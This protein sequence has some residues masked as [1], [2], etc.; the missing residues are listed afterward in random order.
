MPEAGE[1]DVGLTVSCLRHLFTDHLGTGN[2]LPSGPCSTG[3]YCPPG[4]TLA[5]PPSFRCPRGFYCP[6]GSPQPRACENGTFQPQEAQGTCKPCP[7]GFYCEASGSGAPVLAQTLEDFSI[8]T[9]Y[10]KLEDQSLHMAAQLSKHRSDALT[11]YKTAS[12]QL[13]GLQ[14][15]L[16]GL[17][18][19]GLQA[20]GSGQ[21]SEKGAKATAQTDAQQCEEA[22][23]S[24]T[25]AST[26]KCQQPLTGVTDIMVLNHTSM[27]EFILMGFSSF[28]N[29]QLIFF[30]LFL[31]MYLFTLLG[32][33]FIMA[34]IWSE[35]SLHTPMYL[36]LCALSIS[37]IFYT[38]AIIPRM[39]ADLLFT[40][41]SITFVACASQ[42]FFSFMFG[43]T[44]SF[45]LTVMGYDRYVAICHPLRYNVLMSPYGCA[46]LVAW[47]W[48]G[49][50][51]IGMVVTLSVFHLNF[52]GPNVI[53]HF[54]CHVPPLLKLACGRQ[55]QVVAKV[56]GLVCITALLGCCFL[57][58]LSYAFIVATVL[59]IP[60][61]E[62]RHKAFSTC[63]SHLTVV[64]VHYGFASVIYL[65]PS[66]LQSLEGDSLMGITY[67]I[68]TPFLSPIIFSLR[69]KDLKIAMKKSF[70]N[71]LFLQNS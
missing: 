66:G 18:A 23:G 7:E 41:S 25:A 36:F 30:P 38:F 68:L 53:H 12:Q 14:D 60:S 24:H 65:K 26:P 46:C 42:M 10:D 17:H 52:C 34:T 49:G 11:F 33:L 1:A 56:M 4:Q 21:D 51:V 54:F 19:T 67:T 59:K 6:E 16:Q 13:Q 8:R 27:S 70:F 55:V 57:I 5:T 22:G 62:G 50:S 9:L 3:Y 20:L 61:V 35:H 45:L 40:H 29:L 58:L 43:F 28:P 48:A 31:L 37:E 44:H 2:R 32:N 39:L 63:A 47:S 69:N 71:K 15:F 64:V